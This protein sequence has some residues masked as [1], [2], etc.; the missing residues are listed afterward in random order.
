MYQATIVYLSV[1][2]LPNEMLIIK[3][4]KIK[5]CLL[6]RLVPA[7][8]RVYCYPDLVILCIS[9]KMLYIFGFI[10]VDVK[11]HT[12]NCLHSQNKTN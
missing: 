1:H 12:N 6:W 9:I 8:L 5:V 3:K 10:Y 11:Q 7:E 2:T 4:M